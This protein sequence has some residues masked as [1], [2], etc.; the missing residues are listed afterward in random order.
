[1]FNVR[2]AVAI[3]IINKL[4]LR[5][6]TVLDLPNSSHTITTQN[7]VT[8]K[9]LKQ[10]PKV[11]FLK[12]LMSFKNYSKHQASFVHWLNSLLKEQQSGNVCI[13]SG[14]W[15][16]PDVRHLVQGCKLQTLDSL[17]PRIILIPWF[18]IISFRDQIEPELQRAWS[19]LGA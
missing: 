7:S 12:C 15:G 5:I 9:L 11:T 16:A 1:M 13:F 14:G 18:S 19:L 10:E 2:I 4:C 8:F 3:N 17:F 6:I